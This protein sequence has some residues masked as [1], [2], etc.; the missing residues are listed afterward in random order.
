MK[1]RP[2]ITK[3]IRLLK[4]MFILFVFFG[5]GLNIKAETQASLLN[6]QCDWSIQG[7]EAP[8]ALSDSAMLTSF[9]VEKDKPLTIACSTEISFIYILFDRAPS[10]YTITTPTTTQSAGFFGFLHELIPLDTPATTVTLN[11]NPGRIASIF[12]Y[13][14]GILPSTVQIWK[15][16]ST[17]ADLLVFA[18]HGDDEALYFGPAIVKSVDAGKLV[19]VA[20]LTHHFSDRRRPHE[21]LDS[22]WE[23]GVTHYP[24]F[25]PFPDQQSTS[26]K[27]GY[28]IF[29]KD[30]VMAYEILQIRRFKPEVILTHDFAGEYGH[31]AHMVLSD[32][33][34]EAI[35]KSGDITAYPSSAVVYGPFTPLKVYVHLYAENPIILDV[36]T[37]IGSF[38]NRSALEVAR[39]AY[40]YHV[41]QHIWP[42]KVIDYTVGDVRKFGLYSTLVGLDTGNDLFQHVP[43]KV[44]IPEPPLPDPDVMPPTPLFNDNQIRHLFFWLTGGIIVSLSIG[45]ITLG[46]QKR[47]TRRRSF[48]S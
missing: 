20:Y 37:P 2:M 23:L 44:I 16:P 30:K 48:K 24:I 41:S 40:E 32:V 38:G 14:Q 1:A 6:N 42:L 5:S 11:L 19:Q 17:D 39:A 9:L 31:G 27:H 43:P 34:K 46:L 18:T 15:T 7:Q 47:S 8:K 21:T 4:I 25:G 22:L 26:L 10:L 35:L 13:S 45:L 28:T 36:Y 3:K 29:P 33:L 12:V